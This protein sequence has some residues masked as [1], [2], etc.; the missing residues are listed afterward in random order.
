M[1]FNFVFKTSMQNDYLIEYVQDRFLK[2]KKFEL[3]P[4]KVHVQF[5]AQRHGYRIEVTM[6]G[7]NTIYQAEA[8]GEDYFQAI[9]QIVGKILK[10]MA[11][12]KEKLRHRRVEGRKVRN[13]HFEE[14]PMGLPSG[15]RKVA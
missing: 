10:Q 14:V 15:I 12:K 9:D 7:P 1:K 11:R 6:S 8:T 3:Q 4:L 2:L 13:S 5:G